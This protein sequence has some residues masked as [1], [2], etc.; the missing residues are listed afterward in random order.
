MKESKKRK[1][2]RK[3]SKEIA[4]KKV[5]RKHFKEYQQFLS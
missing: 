2:T 4:D 3:A 5:K 1:K